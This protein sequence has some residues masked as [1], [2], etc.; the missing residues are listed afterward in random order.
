M[1][2]SKQGQYELQSKFK[3]SLGNLVRASS[4][5]KKCKKRAEYVSEWHWQLPSM[6][7]GLNLIPTTEKRKRLKYGVCVGGGDTTN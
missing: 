1:A 4:K 5:E 3:V 2:N 6:C 7:E